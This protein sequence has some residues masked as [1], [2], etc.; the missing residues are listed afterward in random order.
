MGSANSWWIIS[1]SR[2]MAVI[3]PLVGGTNMFELLTMTLFV[4]VVLALVAIA[5]MADTIR[6]QNALNLHLQAELWGYRRVG[7]PM[8]GW[9]KKKLGGVGL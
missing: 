8:P 7:R 6:E 2:E 9:M 3:L 4:F 1:A 5:G